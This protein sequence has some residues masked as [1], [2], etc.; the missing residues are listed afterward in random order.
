MF[1]VSLEYSLVQPINVQKKYGCMLINIPS[2]AYWFSKQD[3]TDAWK[4]MLDMK[5]FCPKG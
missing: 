1:A 2:N 5:L 4:D 3:W